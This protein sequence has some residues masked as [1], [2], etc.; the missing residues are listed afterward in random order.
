M[1]VKMN[2]SDQIFTFEINE[3]EDVK[4]NVSQLNM[5]FEGFANFEVIQINERTTFLK[6]NIDNDIKKKKSRN[7]GRKVQHPQEFYTYKQVKEMMKEL[8]N[9]EVAKKLGYIIFALLLY[10]TNISRGIKKLLNINNK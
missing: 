9:D 4:N 10:G 7:A 8:S 1:G 5:I 6:I 2:Y 3:D